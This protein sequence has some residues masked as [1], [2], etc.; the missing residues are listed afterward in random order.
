MENLLGSSLF[1][2]AVS[3]RDCTSIFTGGFAAATV[4]FFAEEDS[5][6]AEAVDFA[7]EDFFFEA[8]ATLVFDDPDDLEAAVFFV[9]DEVD[10]TFLD[11]ALDLDDFK[12]S[13]FFSVADFLSDDLEEV[14]DFAKAASLRRKHARKAKMESRSDWAI[15]ITKARTLAASSEASKIISMSV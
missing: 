15:V 10:A 12:L 8:V 4:D 6:F 11:E 9:E 7:L 5:D 2:A 1:E 14:E 13:L 3:R